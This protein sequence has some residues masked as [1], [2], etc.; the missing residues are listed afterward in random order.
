M[1]QVQLPRRADAIVS[2]AEAEIL[3]GVAMPGVGAAIWQRTLP[4]AVRTWLDAIPAERL[5]QHSGAVLASGAGAAVAAAFDRAGV[6]RSAERDWLADD[7]DRL[8][9]IAGRVLETPFLSLR[10]AAVARRTCPK[11]H[12]DTVRGRLLCTWRGRGTEFGPAR[13]DGTPASVMALPTGAAALF[14]GVLWPGSELTAI[15]HRSPPVETAETP[16][17]MLALDPAEAAGEA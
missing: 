3:S 1:T 4:E 11:W 5:P 6:A 12:V 10:L 14:R 8:A 15:L 7:A 13:P 17:L 2:G 16:R 9:G